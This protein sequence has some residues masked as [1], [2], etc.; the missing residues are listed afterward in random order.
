MPAAVSLDESCG[1]RRRAAAR[2]TTAAATSHGE[3][4]EVGGAGEEDDLVQAVLREEVPEG[5]LDALERTFFFLAM[6]R[7]GG[8]RV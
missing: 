1:Q 2:T 4:D 6:V 8:R 3:S 5:D 7:V